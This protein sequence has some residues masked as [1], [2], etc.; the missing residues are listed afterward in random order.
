[1]IIASG[2]KTE[3]GQPIAGAAGVPHEL[4]G[5]VE[6]SI[7]SAL[8]NVRDPEAM[9][10]AAERMDQLSEQIRKRQ[11]VLNVVVPILREM[12]NGE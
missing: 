6:Q 10:A 4:W 5:E 3:T 11:G 7:Q 1:M 9:R 12:R 2:K 8:S